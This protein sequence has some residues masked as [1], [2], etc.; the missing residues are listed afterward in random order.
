MKNYGE[1]LTKKILASRTNLETMKRFILEWQGADFIQPVKDKCNAV[2]EGQLKKILSQKMVS[3]VYL[4]RF[5]VSW[6]GFSITDDAMEKFEALA[7]S[8]LNKISSSKN[9]N[10]SIKKERIM[11]KR[12]NVGGM[13]MHICYV[14]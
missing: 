13:L 12:Y 1:A 14:Y 2:A 10:S 5:I 4:K 8:A 7:T 11:V 6:N 3:P 9:N